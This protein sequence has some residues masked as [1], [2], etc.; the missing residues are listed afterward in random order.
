MIGRRF[1]KLTILTE[2]GKSRDGQ[3]KYLCACDCGNNSEVVGG[4]L[5]RGDTKSCGCRRHDV[6]VARNTTHGMSHHPR[7]YKLWYSMIQRCHYHKSIS[8]KYYGARGISVCDRWRKFE[9]FYAD[10][11]D[12]PIGL[13]LDRI[14][15]NGNYE[16]GNCRWATTKEQYH[17]RRPRSEWNTNVR[18]SQKDD[19]SPQNNGSSNP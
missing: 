3:I 1:G 9:N 2:S 8:Y 10:M 17:N 11:G 12:R 4:S 14:D 15:N 19:P 18:A 7:M 6:M 16:P 13:S 5:R